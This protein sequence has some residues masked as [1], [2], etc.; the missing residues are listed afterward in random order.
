MIYY[1]EIGIGTAIL[2]IFVA[3]GIGHVRGYSEGLA[4]GRKALEDYHEHTMKN[5]KSLRL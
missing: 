4:Y 5:I 3:Y 2:G 1:I